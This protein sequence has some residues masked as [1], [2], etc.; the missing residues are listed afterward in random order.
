MKI[1]L[2]IKD[3]HVL[4][5]LL[6][7]TTASAIGLVVGYGGT[8]PGAMGHTWG[9]MTCAGCIINSNL[10]DSQVT[11]AKIADSSVTSAKIADGTIATADVSSIDGS[12]ITGTVPNADTVD[13]L[14]SNQLTPSG[15]AVYVCNLPVGG[16][17][18]PSCGTPMCSSQLSTSSVCYYSDGWSCASMSCTYAGRI[19]T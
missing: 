13:G 8:S 7:L 10:G 3:S 18:A 16:Y 15:I 2:N 5:I 1:E 6:F 11:T 17:D 12:K 9:E 19:M 4:I 14:H